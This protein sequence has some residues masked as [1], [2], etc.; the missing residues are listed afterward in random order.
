MR[1]AG[2]AR[3]RSRCRPRRCRCHTPSGTRGCQR[4][5][6]VARGRTPLS[7]GDQ[8]VRDGFL[9]HVAERGAELRAQSSLGLDTT[10]D[11]RIVAHCLLDHV[12]RGRVELAID[13]C[14]QIVIGHVHRISSPS[15][16]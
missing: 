9:E 13:V 8:P 3:D 15:S 12:S 6:V 10:R 4:H 11:L 2:A 7:G 16:V 1:A 5:D 14:H